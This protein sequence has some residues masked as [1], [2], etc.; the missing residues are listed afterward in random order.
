MGNCTVFGI[1]AFRMSGDGGEENTQA[2]IRNDAASR[3]PE[4]GDGQAGAYISVKCIV[5]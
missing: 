1:P 3:G 2:G 5:G 4:Y